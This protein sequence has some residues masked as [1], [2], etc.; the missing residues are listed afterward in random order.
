[1]SIRL[2]HNSLL[3]S[4]SLNYFPDV[5]FE[6]FTAVTMKNIVFCYIYTQF[7]PHRKHVSA[8]EPNRL[9]LC[10][11]WGFHGG[12]YEEC[13]ILGCYVSVD[14]VRTDV[15]EESI[16]SIIRMKRIGELGTLAVTRNWNAPRECTNWE[17][18]MGNYLGI[19]ELV[20]LRCLLQL[21]V[22]ANVF[23]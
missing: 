4:V 22:T 2:I 23:S 21:L 3:Q 16:A 20:F 12:D 10:K 11:I 1:M 7:V 17:Q 6:V 19:R 13:R 9:M 15:S 14:L 8:T 18:I 5:R